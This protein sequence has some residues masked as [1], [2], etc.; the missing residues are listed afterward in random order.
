M[1]TRCRFR[2][3]SFRRARALYFT[4]LV[5]GIFCAPAKLVFGADA[6]RHIPLSLGTDDV[7]PTGNEWI[8]LPE[9]RP[10]DGAIASFNVLSMRDRG[11]LEVRGESESPAL[12]P[13]FTVNGKPLQFRNPAWELIEY[14]IPV[15]HLAVDGLDASITYCAPPGSRGAF[16]HMTVTNR[17]AEAVPIALGM[18][19]SRGA[20]NRVTYLPVALRGERSVAPAPWVDSAE[21][22]PFV[23]NDTQFAWSLI[24]EGSVAHTSVPPQSLSPALDAQRDVTLVPGRAKRLRQI[25][26]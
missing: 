10:A 12:Q 6:P 25:L 14:W 18:K 1:L 26:C 17:R 16:I 5:L 22:F 23:T 11:L 24:H 8:A 7:L 21:V 20:L 3:V 4:L 9:I 15:A 2:L 19:A 13:Y